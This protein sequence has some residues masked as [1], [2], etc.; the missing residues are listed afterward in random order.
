MQRGINYLD[1][2]CDGFS[3]VEQAVVVGESKV[4]HLEM[5]MLAGDNGRNIAWKKSAYRADLDL[6][7]DNDGAVLDGVQAKNGCD[8]SVNA[9][10]GGSKCCQT[11]LGQVDNRSAHH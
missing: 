1:K 5:F 4:H 9:R 2:E 8:A 6:A 3:A 10:R 11:C 7:V